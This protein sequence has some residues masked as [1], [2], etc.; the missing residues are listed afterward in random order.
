MKSPSLFPVPNPEHRTTPHILLAEDDAE[1]RTML[2]CALR[3]DGMQVTEVADG[4]ALR[5]QLLA[6]PE[7]FDLV[8]SD[9][10]MPNLSGLE[11]LGECGATGI[12]VPTVLLTG[13]SD[14]AVA[15]E[16]FRLGAVA[17]LS[18]PFAI[19]DLC[20]AVDHLARSPRRYRR[21]A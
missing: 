18:K 14:E 5:E 20:I 8:V 19:Q 4:L 9:V 21:A 7:N 17:L 11:V 10:N 6:E 16:A 3:R 13:M 2:A 15:R 12:F 1:L